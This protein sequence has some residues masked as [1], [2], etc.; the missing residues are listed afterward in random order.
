MR[1]NIQF[2]A[3]IIALSSIIFSGVIFLNFDKNKNEVNNLISSWY[4]KGPKRSPLYKRIE[5][6]VDNIWII[7]VHSHLG[8]EQTF[9]DRKLKGEIDV[10]KHIMGS[11]VR[12]DLISSGMPPEDLGY[13]LNTENSLEDRWRK[14][15]PYWKNTKNSGDLKNW[16]IAFRDL[17]GITDFNEDTYKEVHRKLIESYNKNGW[18]R[19]VLKEKGKIDLTI[20]DQ[21]NTV[22]KNVTGITG[23]FLLRAER[24]DNFVMVDK[25]SIKSIESDVN[26]SI[27]SLDDLIKALDITIKKGI[28]EKNVIAIK[29]ALAYVRILRFDDVPKIEAEK[30]FNKKFLTEKPVTDEESKKLQDYIMHQI[31]QHS[32]KY[33]VPMA[34]H[35]GWQTGSAGH[36]ITNANPTHLT[37]LFFKFKDA[38][39]DIFHGGYPYMG[40]MGILAKN[41]PNVYI[42]MV[43]MYA[44]GYLSTK[45]Y[46]EEWLD[47]VPNN[48]IIAF[49]GDEGTVEGIYA[50]SRVARRL[51][52]EVLTK[53]VEEGRFSEKEAIEIAQKI[54]R[55]NALTLYK[56]KKEG[57]RFVRI[58]N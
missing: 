33:N 36:Y 24:F 4:L 44:T 7:D 40:E 29:I 52:T 26:I 8:S 16:P 3:L 56:L 54:L 57:D 34:I 17:F 53:K 21:G 25:T 18:Y 45:F 13:V 42:N 35:T 32:I 15:Y 47:I 37:N 31:I 38:R 48:K 39:F 28:E 49:G 9:L 12:N 30:I 23:E 41:F 46:L 58:A 51:I 6:A 50:D 1:K 14:F 10:F 22:A 55:D 20:T 43:N 19:Y 2:L 5:R 11:D 27:N